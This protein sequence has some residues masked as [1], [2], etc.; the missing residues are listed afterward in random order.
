MLHFLKK[1]G[2]ILIAGLCAIRAAGGDAPALTEHNV[3]A[4]CLLNF[5]KYVEWPESAFD[6]P[7]APM[8]IGMVGESKVSG[9]L[10]QEAGGRKIGERPFV[11]RPVRANEDLAGCHIVFVAGSEKG[12]VP[13]LIQSLGARPI[14]TVG[15]T[16]DF[17]KHGGVIALV[18]KDGKVR[19][20]I[21]LA[22]ARQANLQISSKLLAL[23]DDVSG[24]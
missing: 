20:N 16:D 17:R 23:A 22:A 24:K 13:E 5:A 10:E 4:L 1:Q 2:L 3:K 14:L 19:F 18:K 21:N 8:V 15:E 6:N 11:I 12:R 7:A 9:A